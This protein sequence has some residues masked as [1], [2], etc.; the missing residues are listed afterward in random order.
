MRLLNTLCYIIQL[1]EHSKEDENSSTTSPKPEKSSTT[2][3]LVT[4]EETMKSEKERPIMVLGPV[5]ETGTKRKHT[6]ASTATPNATPTPATAPMY[7]P[8]RCYS[9]VKQAVLAFKQSYMMQTNDEIEREIIHKLRKLTAMNKS[10]NNNSNSVDYVE[11]I[12][13]GWRWAKAGEKRNPSASKIKSMSELRSAYRKR[14]EKEYDLKQF[15]PQ[16]FS[17]SSPSSTSSSSSTTTAAAVA[18]VH[19]SS[20]TTS[21]ATIRTSPVSQ[22]KQVRSPIPKKCFRPPISLDDDDDSDNSDGDGSSGNKQYSDNNNYIHMS[23][24][25]SMHINSN[26]D[27]SYE[28]ENVYKKSNINGKRK[29]GFETS[30]GHNFD[31]R[32]YDDTQYDNSNNGDSNYSDD[33]HIDDRYD[34]DDNHTPT[35]D[36]NNN[37]TAT[38]TAAVKDIGQVVGVNGSSNQHHHN[39][40]HRLPT[41]SSHSTHI[42]SNINMSNNRSNKNHSTSSSNTNTTSTTA[43][44][45]RA[46]EDVESVI[47]PSTNHHNKRHRNDSPPP[48]AAAD[49]SNNN[50]DVC[51]S[52]SSEIDNYH[53]QLEQRLIDLTTTCEQALLQY[54]PTFTTHSS[55]AANGTTTNNT[56][57]SSGTTNGS[58]N[59]N[60]ITSRPIPDPNLSD[61]MNRLIVAQDAVDI[62][63]Q[64]NEFISLKE[65]FIEEVDSMIT[66]LEK[67]NRLITERK[68]ANEKVRDSLIP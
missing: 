24:N 6:T 18:V 51:M 56:T 23:N 39:G 46:T 59:N 63:T 50:N 38:A 27:T 68:L 25:N 3:A 40:H 42:K 29:N 17:S 33:M 64:E 4:L 55:S 9:C 62:E 1:Q 35:I 16:P 36:D 67:I 22:Q 13:L 45:V 20:T 12:N 32:M 66:Q 53:P 8:L 52:T 15:N 7:T 2:K 21:T 19:T 5:L 49:N 30:N 11:V 47:Q 48:I 31:P 58:S 14:Y 54:H 43:G 57:N 10:N 60:V 61:N 44:E 28:T 34:D 26:I 37:T 65:R 41:Q